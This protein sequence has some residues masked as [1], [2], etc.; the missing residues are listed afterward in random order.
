[1]QDLKGVIADTVQVILWALLVAAAVILGLRYR[2]N[3][4]KTGWALYKLITAAIVCQALYMGMWA[5]HNDAG[6]CT[7]TV[8]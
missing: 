3:K 6:D 8:P 7:M 4:S 1:M 2:S 5:V